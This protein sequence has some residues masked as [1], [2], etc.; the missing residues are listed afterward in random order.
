[1]TAIVTAITETVVPLVSSVF[2]LIVGNPLLTTFV[3]IGLLGAG[4]RV[5]T[6]LRG[7]AG[8]D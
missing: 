4:I 7:A 5:F 3:G 1:M 6:N 8:A 2:D